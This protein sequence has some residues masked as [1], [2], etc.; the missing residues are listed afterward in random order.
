VLANWGLAECP[1]VY[2]TGKPRGQSTDV[3]IGR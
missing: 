2:P 1:L 3:Q